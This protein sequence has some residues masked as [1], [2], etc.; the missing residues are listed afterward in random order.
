MLYVDRTKCESVPV[1]RQRPIFKNW[2]TFLPLR[3]EKE[4]ALGGF[5][6]LELYPA[7]EEAKDEGE[8]FFVADDS[9]DELVTKKVYFFMRYYFVL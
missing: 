2:K 7:Y 1:R 4:E 8:G 5:G 3:E 9:K 6:L